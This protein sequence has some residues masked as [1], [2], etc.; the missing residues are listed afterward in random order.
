MTDVRYLLVVPTTVA[1]RG[2]SLSKGRSHI[3]L[4]EGYMRGYSGRALSAKS[5]ALTIITIILLA[6]IIWRIST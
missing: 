6:I 5:I 2:Q 4:S 3:S 1:Q